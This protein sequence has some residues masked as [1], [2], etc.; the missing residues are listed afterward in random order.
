MRRAVVALEL[1]DARGWGEAPGEVEDVTHLGRPEAI[2]RLRLVTDDKDADAVGF[3]EPQDRTLQGV[4]VLEL[5]DENVIE[6]TTDGAR[7]FG[8]LHQIMPVQQQV[9]E[10]EHALLEFRLDVGDEKPLQVGLMLGAPGKL[11]AQHG[12]ELLL[13]IDSTRVDGEAGRGLGELQ[14]LRGEPAIAPHDVH[15]TD[16]VVAIQRREAGP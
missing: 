12:L 5:I 3:H 11:C 8:R 14:I 7:D 6:A 2:D 16:A 9:V 15:E 10:V 1:D 13:R 4:G